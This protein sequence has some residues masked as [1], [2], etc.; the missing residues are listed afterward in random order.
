MGCRPNHTTFAPS[1]FVGQD[2]TTHLSE[3]QRLD[4]ARTESATSQTYEDI[5]PFYGQGKRWVITTFFNTDFLLAD[6]IERDPRT[7]LYPPW[8]CTDL[9]DDVSGNTEFPSD[10]DCDTTACRHANTFKDI[11]DRGGMVLTGTDAPLIYNGLGV[12]EN[13]RALE[14]YAFSP[15]E[16]L[17]T[18]TRFP[19]EHFG[20][21]EDLGTL[22]PGKLADMVFV[23]GNP[24]ERIED[25]M[26]VKMTMKN[27]ELFTIRDLVAPFVPEDDLDDDFEDDEEDGGH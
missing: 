16:A 25:A 4:Y 10:P 15:Y 5:I 18:A 22:E 27:G 23:E 2:G 9:R 17:L 21:D 14:A 13:L 26:Q 7:Q 11:L 20:V 12:H 8:V 3:T 6:E 19:A 1:A 24:I